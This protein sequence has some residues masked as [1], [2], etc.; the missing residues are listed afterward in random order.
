M[1]FLQPKNVIQK[2]TEATNRQCLRLLSICLF[3]LSV[4]ISTR[5]SDLIISIK[6]SQNSSD[7]SVCFSVAEKQITL[8]NFQNMQSK[9]VVSY[10]ERICLFKKNI[11]LPLMSLTGPVTKTENIKTDSTKILRPTH[12]FGLERY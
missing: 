1:L 9:K 2:L 6:R 7:C 10:C 5:K 11:F 3:K 12:F 8:S 4:C